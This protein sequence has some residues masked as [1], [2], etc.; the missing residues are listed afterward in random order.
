MADLDTRS[1]AASSVNILLP[2]V[3]APP[4]PTGG[5][6]TQGDLQ[7]IALSFSGALATSVAVVYLSI[8]PILQAT[9]IEAPILA[10]AEAQTPNL[11]AAEIDVPGLRASEEF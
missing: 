9:E 10:V 1:L 5:A 7:H 8:G 3:L 4:L 11:Q 2:F 6:F